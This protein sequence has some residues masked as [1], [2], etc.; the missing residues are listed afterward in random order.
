MTK[1]RYLGW[2]GYADGAFAATLYGRTGLEIGGDNH[3]S[4]DLACRRL[5][6]KPEA[7]D[8]IN[9]NTPFVRDVLY[10]SGLIRSLSNDLAM[11]ARGIT[12]AFSRFRAAA[13]SHDGQ[14]IGIPQRCGPFNLVINEKRLSS[15]S[16]REQGFNLALQPSFNGRFGILAYDDFNVM[17]IAIAAGL[18]PFQPFD[19]RATNIFS[20]T[21]RKIFQSARLVTTDHNALNRALIN[22]QIDF[23]I[24]GGIYTAS[25]ARLAGCLEVK[26]I[27]PSHGPIGGKGGVAF[28]EVNAITAN[29]NLQGDAA[30][31]FLAFVASDD[32]A[33]AA[34]LAA[35]ACNPVVQMHRSSLFQRFMRDQLEA[36]QW[37]DFEHDMLCCADYA[38]IPDYLKLFRLCRAQGPEHW[39]LR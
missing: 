1:L 22:G 11:S 15:S 34:S 36:M 35:D 26:A 29:G 18:N 28:V 2:E 3:L 16:A 12:G 24:S 7:W 19:D 38:T 39:Y 13:E 30:H 25:P 5:V 21:A 20:E 8:I 4:D 10:P 6:A 23:Y 17:H 14:I 31:A 9:I 32:G 37:D 33:L 27:T